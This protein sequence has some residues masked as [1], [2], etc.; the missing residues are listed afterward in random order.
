M[1]EPAPNHSKRSE[2]FD[3]RHFFDT[4]TACLHPLPVR[5][6]A[7]PLPSG[8]GSSVYPSCVSRQGKVSSTVP[9][10][11]GVLPGVKASSCCTRSQFASMAVTVP[12]ALRVCQ[13]PG[14]GLLPFFG[15]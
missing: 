15:V 6:P 7:L 10:I 3:K 2:P 9:Y 1:L 14:C 12:G 11:A 4:P 8:L 13:L 5:R